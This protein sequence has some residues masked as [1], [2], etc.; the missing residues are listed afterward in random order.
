MTVIN[1]KCPNCGGEMEHVE[2]ADGKHDVF[3]HYCGHHIYLDNDNHKVI[4]HRT[5]DVAKLEAIKVAAAEK[6]KANK[7]LGKVILGGGIVAVLGFGLG[8]LIHS[9]GLKTLGVFGVI[10][11]LFSVAYL[12]GV[13]TKD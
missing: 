11:I 9:E 8:G 2:L 1:L 5:V 4:E 13:N 10:G 3:C 12:I 6:S 7:V